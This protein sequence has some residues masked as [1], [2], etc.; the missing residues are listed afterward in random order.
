M[1]ATKI[2]L[3]GDSG[4]GKTSLI[5][6]YQKGISSRYQGYADWDKSIGASYKPGKIL[7]QNEVIQHIVLAYDTPGG[8]NWQKMRTEIVYP[9]IKPDIF[10]VCFS[11]DS[12]SSYENVKNVYVPEIRQHCPEIPFL[13]VGTKMDLFDQEKNEEDWRVST[14][15]ARYHTAIELGAYKY[16]EC[17]AKGLCLIELQ[18]VITQAEHSA[19]YEKW[20]RRRTGCPKNF[21]S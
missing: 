12:Y 18:N 7:K 9:N 21:F 11:V 3:I 5:Y 19:E 10:L 20:K 6:S 8:E 1:E 17:T 4:V 14:D 16:M 15:E 2:V 13:I